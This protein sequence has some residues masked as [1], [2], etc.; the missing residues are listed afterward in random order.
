MIPGFSSRVASGTIPVLKVFYYAD[1]KKRPGTPEGDA[2]I[3]E[4]SSG[5]PG[6]TKS[7]R[8]LKEMQISYGAM[9]GTKL[10]PDWE[11]WSALGQVLIP[12]FV[13]QG[14][15]LYGSYD[16]G[17]R[18]PAAF[19]VHGING[20]GEIV[21][22]WEFYASNVPVGMIARLIQGESVT[23]PDG[24]RFAGNPYAG[25]LTWAVADPSIWAEDQPMVDNTNKSIAELFRRHGVFFHKGERGG[26]TM[27]AE[28][29]LG[30]YWAD[31]QHPRYRIT[32]ECPKLIWELGQQRHKEIAPHL[33]LNANHPEQLVDKNNHAWDGLKMFL[34][35]F[36]PA[37]SKPRPEQ[38][39]G[40][41]AW[42]RDQAKRAK[43]GRP[44]QTYR[45][46]MIS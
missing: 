32:T 29:L 31:P 19:H 41:F 36:P 12:P 27:V 37:A 22:L 18:N 16:H 40:S 44:I 23:T 13:P 3:Q 26:D 5:Y 11:Q 9:G 2:W 30:H 15:K 45:R 43:D 34:Q 38:R 33:T 6:G 14:Y 7:P 8:W 10:F 4:A 20:D 21:T 35:R 42:F 39:G 1:P 24:R 25:D 28:W 17:W 46:A